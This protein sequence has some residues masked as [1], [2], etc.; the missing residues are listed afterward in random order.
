MTVEEAKGLLG[1]TGVPTPENIRKAYRRMAMN[2]HPDRYRTFSEKAW[3][4]RK[5]IKITEARDVLVEGLA[6]GEASTWE[7]YQGQSQE[8]YSGEAPRPFAE[9]NPFARAEQSIASFS[10]FAWYDHLFEWV[11]GLPLPFP[12]DEVAYIPIGVIGMLLLPLFVYFII[13]IGVLVNIC[14]EC[15]IEAYPGSRNIYG[16]LSYLLIITL[17]SSPFFVLP[18]F[19]LPSFADRRG[20]FLVGIAFA[21]VMVLSVLIEWGGF[22]LAEAWGRSASAELQG[23]LAPRGSG[24]RRGRT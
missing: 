7:H 1:I 16:R 10:L 12:L 13:S 5:F 9:S 19:V 11:R 3:A 23:L 17:V 18:F 8:N 6:S 20:A 15:G 22:I 21:G 14:N 24:E 2:S 4:T